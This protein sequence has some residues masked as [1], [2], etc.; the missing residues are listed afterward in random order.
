MSRQYGINNLHLLTTTAEKFFASPGFS[1][2]PRDEAPASMKAT[3]EFSSI[4]PSSSTYMVMRDIQK[5]EACF[6]NDTQIFHQD[7][8]SG[9]KYWAVNGENS[10][11]T[12]FEVPPN[13]EFTSH[14]HE[15]EQITYVLE[16]ELCFE[17]ANKKHRLAAGDTIIIPPN[18]SHRVWT[19][20]KHAKAIDSW[21]PVNEKYSLVEKDHQTIKQ[22]V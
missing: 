22:K 3:S 18:K 14:Q 21:S 9:S 13:T 12:Y 10:M 2:V 15:S 6:Y 7:K 8:E 17:I 19:E 20:N 5:K 4:C 16:G 11:L 1:V